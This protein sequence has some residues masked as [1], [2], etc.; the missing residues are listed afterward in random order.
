MNFA[1]SSRKRLAW[2][3][4]YVRRWSHCRSRRDA[5]LST[6]PSPSARTRDIDLLVVADNTELEQIYAALMPVEQSLARP[7]SLTLYTEEEY[8]RRRK[9]GN[10]FLQRVLDGPIIDLI[11]SADVD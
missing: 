1:E 2:P 4:L 5:R 10:P 8:E 9:D 11:G 7:I 3:V 6:V